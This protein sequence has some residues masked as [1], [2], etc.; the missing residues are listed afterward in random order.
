MDQKARGLGACV[1]D[2]GLLRFAAVPDLWFARWP[3]VSGWASSGID[4]SAES[5]FANDAESWL[6]EYELFAEVVL[7]HD[8]KNNAHVN[9]AG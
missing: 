8:A 9:E 2:E 5:V 7:D 4:E 6:A 3:D 1:E